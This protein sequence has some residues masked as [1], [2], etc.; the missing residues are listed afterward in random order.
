MNAAM[1]IYELLKHRFKSFLNGFKTNK[2]VKKMERKEC[3]FDECS[4]LNKHIMSFKHEAK[5]I[6]YNSKS[7][8]SY[9][10]MEELINSDNSDINII[11]RSVMSNEIISYIYENYNNHFISINAIGDSL[12]YSVKVIEKS[13]LIRLFSDGKEVDA[14]E[15]LLNDSIGFRYINE[16]TESGVVKYKC[17]SLH[18]DANV[19]ILN[20]DPINMMS[21]FK[22]LLNIF[23]KNTT[24]VTD[25]FLVNEQ[26]I[27]TMNKDN[28]IGYDE[29]LKCV[30]GDKTLEEYIKFEKIF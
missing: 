1:I 8:T 30:L 15:K 17:M 3:Y 25:I 2:T 7:I 4:I 22:S 10:N 21:N 9:N 26:F 20:G 18:L 11:I 6:D 24:E 14:T 27:K 23:D 16:Y 13:N 12:Q 19:Q 28:I 5:L 29:I